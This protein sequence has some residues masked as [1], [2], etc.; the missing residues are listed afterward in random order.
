MQT[1]ARLANDHP[2]TTLWVRGIFALADGRRITRTVRWDGEVAADDE[3]RKAVL[4]YELIE[5]LEH[6]GH[7][8]RE[9]HAVLVEL[10]GVATG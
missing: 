8:V 3:E 9:G 1:V 4:A 2:A 7:D 10:L 5:T 6:G